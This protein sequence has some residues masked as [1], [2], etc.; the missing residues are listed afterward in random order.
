MDREQTLPGYLAEGASHP[1]ECCLPVLSPYCHGCKQRGADGNE[2]SREGVNSNLHGVV[3]GLH[4]ETG[5]S[6]TI[7]TAVPREE[8]LPPHPLGV[9]ARA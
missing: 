5:D 3:Q 6:S 9:Q 7:S 1:A 8:L 2:S 4:R